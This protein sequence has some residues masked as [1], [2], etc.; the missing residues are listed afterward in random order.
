MITLL[1]IKQ[2]IL[3]IIRQERFTN[4]SVFDFVEML[5]TSTKRYIIVSSYVFLLLRFF[6]QIVTLKLL[7]TYHNI[8]ALHSNRYLKATSHIITVKLFQTNHFIKTVS[9]KSLH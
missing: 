9:H 2:L 8:S 7:H 3:L 4:V 5:L 1:R 6:K